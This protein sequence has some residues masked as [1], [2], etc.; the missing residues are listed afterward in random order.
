MLCKSNLTTYRWVWWSVKLCLYDV[1][2]MNILS[3]HILFLRHPTIYQVI[4]CFSCWSICASIS[5]FAYTHF[6][7]FFDERVQESN[8]TNRLCNRII[9]TL[10]TCLVSCP[11]YFYVLYPIPW[12]TSTR[13]LIKY[14]LMKKSRW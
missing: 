3:V 7:L 5:Y 4:I 11:V 13:F 1:Y 6:F 14:I 10:D 2:L 12:H 8:Q 9:H